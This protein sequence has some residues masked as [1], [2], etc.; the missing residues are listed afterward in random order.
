MF[1]SESVLYDFPI[2]DPIPADDASI[3]EL[4]SFLERYGDALLDVVDPQTSRRSG[5]NLFDHMERDFSQRP[6]LLKRLRSI[7]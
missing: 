4:S 7:L 2:P 3:G 6:V 5:V 1:E